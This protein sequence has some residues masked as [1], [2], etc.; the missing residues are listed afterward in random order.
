MNISARLNS[1]IIPKTDNSKDLG[2]SSLQFRDVYIDGELH[3]DTLT[4]AVGQNIDVDRDLDLG[5]NVMIDYATSASSVGASGSADSLPTPFA[6]VPC[7]INGTEYRMA[8]FQ[9]ALAL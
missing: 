4:N 5:N 6:Y 3:V 7:R 2:S 8:I 9:Q 1:S